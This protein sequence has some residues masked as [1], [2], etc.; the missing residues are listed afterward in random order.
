M[1]GK[2]AQVKM[3]A[4]GRL[5]MNKA[6]LGEQLEAGGPGQRELRKSKAC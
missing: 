3:A 2:L 6:K 1:Q 5:R 4:Q